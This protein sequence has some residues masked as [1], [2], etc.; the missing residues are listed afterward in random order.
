[1]CII[2]DIPYMFDIVIL[3]MAKISLNMRLIINYHQKKCT[4]K[5]TFCYIAFV[6]QSHFE[7]WKYFGSEMKISGIWTACN[8][9]QL[10]GYSAPD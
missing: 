9:H 1:M 6:A 7:K 3:N 8:V 2:V 5:S 10:K 4:Q